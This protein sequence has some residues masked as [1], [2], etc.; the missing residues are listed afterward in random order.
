[1]ENTIKRNAKDSRGFLQ[2][3]DT[4]LVGN[5]P[6]YV[7]QVEATLDQASLNG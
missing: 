6:V 3:A 1:M 4:W 7:A 2:D 5:D